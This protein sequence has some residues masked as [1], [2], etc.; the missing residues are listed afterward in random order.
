MQISFNRLTFNQTVAHPHQGTLRSNEGECMHWHM[1]HLTH[2]TPGWGSKASCRGKASLQGWPSV[3]L[4]YVIFLKRQNHSN[5]EQSLVHGC[6]GRA[7]HREMECKSS[8]GRWTVH[9]LCVC[10]NLCN[11]TPKK[12]MHILLSVINNLKIKNLI[13]ICIKLKFIKFKF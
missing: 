2:A 4:P 13:L 1:P 6:G 9:N 11:C 7:D 12:D 5:R 8:S 10:L 3:R